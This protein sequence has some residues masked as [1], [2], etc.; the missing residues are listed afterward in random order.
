MAITGALFMRIWTAALLNPGIK[1]GSDLDK[2]RDC[3]VFRMKDGR[4]INKSKG[5]DG[6]LTVHDT[7]KEAMNAA[8]EVLNNHGGGRL[9]V[10]GWDGRIKFKDTIKAS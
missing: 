10:K 4:W 2:G 7:R 8:R 9:T 1:G 6:A 5:D 3:T